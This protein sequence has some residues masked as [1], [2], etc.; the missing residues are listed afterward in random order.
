MAAS[1]CSQAAL[2]HEMV[3]VAHHVILVASG[4]RQPP[5]KNSAVRVLTRFTQGADAPRSHLLI[6]LRI[7]H[8]PC[9][10]DHRDFDLARI[11][12]L[13]FDGLGD[14]AAGFLGFLVGDLFGVGD[15]P[16]FTAGLDGEGLVDAVETTSD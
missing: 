3:Y 2:V 1:V 4:G 12:H 9:F 14:V 7:L 10:P 8:I 16:N 15:H 13:L 6:L 11:V 5:E